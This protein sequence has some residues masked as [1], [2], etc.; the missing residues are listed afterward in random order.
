VKKQFFI[1]VL[2]LLTCN[3]YSQDI[4]DVYELQRLKAP[5]LKKV[6]VKFSNKKVYNLT[7]K[8]TLHKNGKYLRKI[9]NTYHLLESYEEN[10][11]W[12]IKNDY[13]YLN[14]T[15]FRIPETETK[16]T[17]FN[18]TDMFLIKRNKI[19]PVFNQSLYRKKKLK[20]NKK[21]LLTPYKMHA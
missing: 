18:R 5:F 6:R 9:Y 3:L 19:I 12:E 4:K 7:D 21:R 17:D 20:R 10:G 14:L 15:Q 8:L 13:L 16:W 1:I 11:T 2:I